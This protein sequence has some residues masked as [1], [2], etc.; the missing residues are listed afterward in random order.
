M[1]AIR[2]CWLCEAKHL[3]EVEKQVICITKA[4]CRGRFKSLKIGY[5]SSNSN[6][7][8]ERPGNS[9]M[10]NDTCF[11]IW[12]FC[13]FTSLKV[14]C[15]DNNMK[16]TNCPR[17]E[18]SGKKLPVLNKAQRS[19]QTTHVS[20]LQGSFALTLCLH[21][22]FVKMVLNSEQMDVWIKT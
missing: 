2:W 13:N 14:W 8:A 18:N 19:D 5:N 4:L 16:V 12:L 17:T 21:S 6:E 1:V 15:F 10:R 11:N 3:Q 20:V 9:I 7:A 22:H